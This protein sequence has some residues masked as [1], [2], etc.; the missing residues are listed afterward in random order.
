MEEKLATNNFNSNLNYYND[1]SFNFNFNANFD[2]DEEN[3]NLN[4]GNLEQLPGKK[5]GYFFM[6]EICP[7]M[8]GMNEEKLYLSWENLLMNELGLE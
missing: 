8:N 1:N 5:D 4:G 7:Q 2:F 3:R 6:K